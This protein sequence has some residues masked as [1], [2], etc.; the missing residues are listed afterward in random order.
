[1]RPKITSKDRLAMYYIINTMI[2]TS[3]DAP[4]I[5]KKRV[6]TQMPQLDPTN[7]LHTALI[8]LSACLFMT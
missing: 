2:K 5:S 7:P 8:S 4:L 1:M 3:F 6:E